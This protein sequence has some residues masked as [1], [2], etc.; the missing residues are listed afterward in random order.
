MVDC[1]SSLEYFIMLSL[2]GDRLKIRDNLELKKNLRA[3]P[4]LQYMTIN[5]LFLKFAITLAPI[6]G[7][8]TNFQC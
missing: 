5:T 3:Q 4:N 6:V 7:S 2:K 1:Y 8:S